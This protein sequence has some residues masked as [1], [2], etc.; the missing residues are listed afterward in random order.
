MIVSQAVV[1]EKNI[2]NATENNRKEEQCCQKDKTHLP[3]DDQKG[4]D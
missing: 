4:F 2:S 3:E 1:P